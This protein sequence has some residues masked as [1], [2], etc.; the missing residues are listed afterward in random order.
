MVA[1]SGFRISE[2]HAYI[3]VTENGDEGIAA[4]LS[5][6]V[7]MP[8]ICA[9]MARVESMRP[10]ARRIAEATGQEVRLVK[11]ATRT[12]VETIGGGR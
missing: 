9:D 3:V 7:W 2:V 10:M 4:F 6:G 8:M 12:D 5:E 11:F 1:Q